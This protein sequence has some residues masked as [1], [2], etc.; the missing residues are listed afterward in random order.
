[1]GLQDELLVLST[2]TWV[3]PP[4]V[5]SGCESYKQAFNNQ[6]ENNILLPRPKKTQI[7]RLAKPHGIFEARSDPSKHLRLE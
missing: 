1:M 3:V 5:A 2:K 4:G 6:D 7:N